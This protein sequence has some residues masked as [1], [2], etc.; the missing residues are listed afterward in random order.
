MYEQFYNLREKPFNLTPS[1]RFL[2][3]GEKHKE[4]LAM[5]KYGVMERKGF[6]LLTGEVG[7]GKTTMVRALLDGLDNSVRYVHLSNPLLSQKDFMSY[8]AFSAFKKWVHFKSKAQFLAT[9]ES[10]LEMCLE[11]ELNFNLIIDEAHKL[12]FDLL[13]EIRL[14]SN[15]ET[16]DEKL[17]N[18]F[19]VGQPELNEKL[20]DPKSRAL[21]QRIAIRYHIPPLNPDETKEY[22]RTRWKAA[23]GEDFEKFFQKA[24]VGALHRFSGGYPRMINILADN[25]LLLGY[26]RGKNKIT[27][28]MIQECHKDMQLESPYNEPEEPAEKQSPDEST[29]TGEAPK[30]RRWRWA[31]LAVFI[32][33][34][35][36]V[37]LGVSDKGREVTSRLLELAPADVR[38]FF[39]QSP[40]AP[41]V[42]PEEKQEYE[43][44]ETEKGQTEG[45][46]KEEPP[47][48]Q[49]KAETGVVTLASALETEEVESP[50]VPEKE[51]ALKSLVVKPGDTLLEL[52]IRVYGTAN[53]T[54]LDRV[55]QSNPGIKDVNRI[56]VG[57]EILFPPLEGEEKMGTFTVHIASFKGFERARDYFQDLVEAGY[58]AYIIPANDPGKGAVFRIALGS[59]DIREDGDAY[60]ALILN[61]RVSDYAETIELEMK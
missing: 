22:M 28:A 10:F 40:Q 19:L 37:G 54:I 61:R 3:L 51:E 26:S 25:A 45:E 60:A 50:L 32:I 43:S 31:A 9:F 30:R 13:E 12:S 53:E 57:Q 52:A 46:P 14:L 59:F 55:R 4:A 21:L 24:I 35:V 8:I 49:E 5:L 17:I 48:P 44:F 23:G 42:V 1:T 11:R 20:R 41:L 58:E 7:T 38:S 15:M 39:D 18:I 47:V 29:G 36:L 2:Y 27:E 56:E 16:G 33:V 6:I 34:F